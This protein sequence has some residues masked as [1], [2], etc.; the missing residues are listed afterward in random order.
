MPRRNI[1][2]IRMPRLFAFGDYRQDTC[3]HFA[4]PTDRNLYANTRLDDGDCLQS[5]AVRCYVAACRDEFDGQNGVS[6]AISQGNQVY[7]VELAYAKAR[8]IRS[9]TGQLQR[10]LFRIDMERRRCQSKGNIHQ[11]PR[12][13]VPQIL[14]PC[15]QATSHG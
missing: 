15:D 12:I 3:T 1:R 8:V 5:A 9:I 10:V 13:F 11:R 6:A 4:L 2:H 14:V 7:G